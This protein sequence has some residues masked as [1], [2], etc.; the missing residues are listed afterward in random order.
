M[1]GVQGDIQSE[2]QI[3]VVSNTPIVP[4]T[5]CDWAIVCLWSMG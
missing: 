3:P 5:Y 1:N 4:L 2:W